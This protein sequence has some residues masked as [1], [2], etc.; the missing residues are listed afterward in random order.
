MSRL[1]NDARL[2]QSDDQRAL[3]Q[4]LYELQRDTANQVN[5]LSEGAIRACTNATAAAPATGSYTPGD[6]VRNCA[7][8]ELGTVGSKYVVEGWLCIAA[9]A[10]FVDKRFFTGN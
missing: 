1:S 10:T 5:A 6:F 8:Q 7:P 2:P 3:K 4:R 9:P